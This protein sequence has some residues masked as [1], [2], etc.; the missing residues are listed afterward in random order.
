MR[1]QEKHNISDGHH[2]MMMK[3][4]ELNRILYQQKKSSFIMLLPKKVHK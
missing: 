2:S 3:V 1:N 4:Y